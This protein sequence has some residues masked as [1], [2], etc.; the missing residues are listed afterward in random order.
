MLRLGGE[1]IR[2]GLWLLLQL[3]GEVCWRLTTEDA[4]L[5]LP[6]SSSGS[7][8]QGGLLGPRCIG[9]ECLCRRR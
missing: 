7:R 9:F 8:G 2:T 3:E 4:G 1:E 5:P 6:T